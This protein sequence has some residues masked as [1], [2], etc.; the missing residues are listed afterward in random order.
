M[1]INNISAHLFIKSLPYRNYPH[2]AD[3]SISKHHNNEENMQIIAGQL[4]KELMNEEKINQTSLTK[5]QA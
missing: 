3:I 4:I 5:K 1:L 2:S